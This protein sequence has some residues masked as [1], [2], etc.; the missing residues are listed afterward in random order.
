MQYDLTSLKCLLLYCTFL[1]ADKH[2]FTT[3]LKLD[4]FS[5][6]IGMF[7]FRKINITFNPITGKN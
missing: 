4:M 1:I 7:F 6:G 3:N 5:Q 2:L